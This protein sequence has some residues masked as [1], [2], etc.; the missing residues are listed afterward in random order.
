MAFNDTI[1]VFEISTAVEF[2][3]IEFS[4]I[5]FEIKCHQTTYSTMYANSV[6]FHI[7]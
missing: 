3:Q 1:Q 6:Y 7:L 5:F 2:V 4:F